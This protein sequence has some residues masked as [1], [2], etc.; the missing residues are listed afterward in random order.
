MSITVECRNCGKKYAVDEHLA[1]RKFRCHN[2]G[3]VFPADEPADFDAIFASASAASAEPGA[4]PARAPVFHSPPP[5]PPAPSLFA[6]ATPAPS[7]FAAAPAFVPPTRRRKKENRVAGSDSATPWL[8][9]LYLGV[10]IFYIIGGMWQH[11][12]SGEGDTIAS[13]FT[14][15]VT[16]SILFFAVVAPALWLGVFIASKVMKFPLVEAAYL[17]AA[18][19]AAVPAVV[20]GLIMFWLFVL[21]S[22]FPPNLVIIGLLFLAMA[23]IA[24]FV[25][26]FA[27]ALDLKEAIVGFLFTAP[28]YVM[29][30]FA[31][32]AVA[33]LAASMVPTERKAHRHF[34]DAP[35]DDQTAQ[36]D[37]PFVNS[38]QGTNF[39]MPTPQ[40]AA[41]ARI[42]SFQS[43]VARLTNEAASD[44][45]RESMQRRLDLLRSQIMSDRALQARSTYADLQSQ[46]TQLQQ[47]IAALPS[48][49]PDQ[50]VFSDPVPSQVWDTPAGSGDVGTEVSYKDFK[51]RPPLD[52]VVDLKSSEN[53]PAGLVWTFRKTFGARFSITTLPRTN[54]AQRQP[55]VVCRPFMTPETDAQKLFCI[56]VRDMARRRAST[57]LTVEDGKIGNL[58]FTRV[59]LVPTTGLGD[60]FAQYA[61][62]SDNR[63]LVMTIRAPRDEARVFGQMQ[64]SAGSVR[65]AAGE[66][67]VDPFSPAALVARL[68]DEPLEVSVMLRRQG[69]AAEPALDAA[70]KDPDARIAEG[71]AALLDDMAT[72]K[73]VPVLR[74]AATSTDPKVRESARA[75]LNRLLPKE[76]DVVAE[77]LLDLQSD[78]ILDK[79]TAL[80]SLARATPDARRAQIATMLEDM[81]ASDKPNLDY[82]DLGKALAAWHGDNTMTRLLPLLAIKG[83]SPKRRAAMQALG[84]TKDKRVALPLMD[85][86]LLDDPD[87]AVSALIELG[88]PAEDELVRQKAMWHANARVRTAAARVL[89]EIGTT[90]S[91]PSLERGAHDPRDA[92][93]A[94]AARQALA[95]VKARLPKP[96]TLATKAG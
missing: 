41:D 81:L 87:A 43:Q 36:N 76:F 53:D 92:S 95:A 86:W 58:A 47:K 33:I 5:P 49:T 21:P 84:G 39:G 78:A 1:G 19:V 37:N 50:A 57:D 32:I 73:S 77:A 63:W 40:D 83:F 67:H 93:A 34:A 17:K 3:N 35:G 20:F 56:D 68:G 59:I 9:I 16:N 8:I 91:L 25:F 46:L 94:A 96:G 28:L 12:S 60:R 72:P 65:T 23:P 74:E 90:K 42:N 13:I 71:A 6:P 89:Q 80:Q 2:C 4:E 15:V 64:A 18:A 45:S 48:E 38:P 70:M 31:S 66:P 82:E 52:A 27:F 30:Q 85:P 61:A 14:C 55:W 51:L 26:K 29:G 22:V 24:F 62:I 54:V 44:E 10:Q 7:Y 69:P 75:A 11:Y 79:R 88:Q